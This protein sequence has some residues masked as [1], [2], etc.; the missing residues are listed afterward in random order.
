MAIMRPDAESPEMKKHCETVDA[1]AANLLGTFGT[2]SLGIATDVL[3]SVIINIAA[4]VQG[5]QWEVILADTISVLKANV[6]QQAVT[7]AL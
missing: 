4:R 2:A 1:V 7:N 3:G 5:Q 6:K